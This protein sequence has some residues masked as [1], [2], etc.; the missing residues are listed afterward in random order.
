MLIVRVNVVLTLILILCNKENLVQNN[1]SYV[2]HTR[3][4]FNLY[5]FRN[6]GKYYENRSLR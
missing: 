4:T 6:S 2:K 3:K 5:K 1:F